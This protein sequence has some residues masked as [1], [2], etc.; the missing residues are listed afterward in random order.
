MNMELYVAINHRDRMRAHR[1]KLRVRNALKRGT[2][3][4]PRLSVFRS[5]HHIYVQM[6]DDICGKTLASSSSLVIPAAKGD[7]K[8][9]ARLVG[10]D[11]ASQAQKQGLT[12]AFFDRG[13]SRYTGRVKALADGVR[14]GGIQI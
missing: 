2:A 4:K 10:L 14:E 8:A 11:L 3:V 6:I 1:R 7:K 9:I 13:S 12:V 5:L